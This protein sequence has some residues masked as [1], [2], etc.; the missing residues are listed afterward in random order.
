MTSRHAESTGACVTE[1]RDA[2]A[3]NL[4]RYGCDPAFIDAFRWTDI[5]SDEVHIRAYDRRHPARVAT[6]R[7]RV[8]RYRREHCDEDRS[9][10]LPLD[11]ILWLLRSDA[12]GGSER[13][14]WGY[15]LLCLMCTLGLSLEEAVSA[16]AAAPL[17]Y[18][19]PEAAAG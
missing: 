9:V 11:P 19:G 17:W 6:W 10:Y 13:A 3:A 14:R 7:T 1:A 18:R 5:V 12:D 2:I 4:S 15:T 16:C 8:A